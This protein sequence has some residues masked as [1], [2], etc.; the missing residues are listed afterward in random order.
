MRLSSVKSSNF[1]L[2][3]IGTVRL[4]RYQSAA[5]VIPTRPK[6]KNI[7]PF[8]FPAVNGAR[9]KR[10]SLGKKYRCSL[11]CSKK[12]A[13]VS[14]CSYALERN[15]VHN[16]SSAYGMSTPYREIKRARK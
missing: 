14:E 12:S 5:D 15:G 3:V 16:H 7:A 8:V 13:T 9:M 6:E 10:R 4:S 1:L 11:C 2:A